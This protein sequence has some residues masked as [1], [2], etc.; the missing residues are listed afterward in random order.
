MEP[1][2]TNRVS[3]PLDPYGPTR[4][5]SYDDV[6]FGMHDPAGNVALA[7]VCENA[8]AVLRAGLGRQVA[9]HALHGGL[10]ALESAGEHREW[11]DTVVRETISFV[12]EPVCEQFG[13]APF[14]DDEV[15]AVCL[16]FAERALDSMTT[17]FTRGLAGL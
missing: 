2:T 1:M 5:G 4:T 15:N 8:D 10:F 14:T 16:A 6:D 9:L 17:G 11:S 13:F 3:A 7:Q 12:L